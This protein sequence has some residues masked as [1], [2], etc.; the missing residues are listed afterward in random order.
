MLGVRML[1]GFPGVVT[2]GTQG[3]VWSH[4]THEW[5]GVHVSNE[6]SMNLE[7]RPVMMY[8]LD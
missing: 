3:S 4:L 7:C 8:G 5:A 1:R 2:A 6:F